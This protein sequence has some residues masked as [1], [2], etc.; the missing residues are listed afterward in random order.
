MSWVCPI[1]GGAAMPP[2]H[3]ALHLGLAG[4]VVA[5][6]PV[7]I[8]LAVRAYRRPIET[9]AGRP[10]PAGEGASPSARSGCAC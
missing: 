10:G 9:T 7:F 1:V 8:G 5:A 4:F 3:V 6:G 2:W